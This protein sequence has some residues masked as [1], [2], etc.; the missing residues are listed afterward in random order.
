[1]RCL[2]ASG[3]AQSPKYSLESSQK[4]KKE[5]NF[6][7]FPVYQGDRCWAFTNDGGGVSGAVFRSYI[8][9]YLVTKRFAAPLW[10]SLHSR[11]HLLYGSTQRGR[12]RKIK[13][14]ITAVVVEQPSFLGNG[15]GMGHGTASGLFQYEKN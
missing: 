10:F 15:G 5:S 1:M 9:F 6:T 8:L 4:N 7:P 2:A 13:K 11:F 12:N 14:E 3:E